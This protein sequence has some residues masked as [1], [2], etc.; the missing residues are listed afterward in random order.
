MQY[1]LAALRHGIDGVTYQVGEHLPQFAGKSAHG[2][3]RVQAL[4]YLD[5][6]S[7]DLRRVQN[8]HALQYFRQVNVNR[9]ARFAME[10]QQLPG[11]LGD[12]RQLVTGHLQI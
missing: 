12:T 11:D 10:G 5:V 7:P 8:E 4:F 6:T 1:E 3:G 2:A 9:T